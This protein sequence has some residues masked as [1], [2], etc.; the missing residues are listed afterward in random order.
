MAAR[1]L[2][3]EACMKLARQTAMVLV[4]ALSA[5]AADDGELPSEEGIAGEENGDSKGDRDDAA[6]TTFD[7]WASP[8]WSEIRKVFTSAAAYEEYF[9]V[10]APPEVD[11]SRD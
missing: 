10:P 8:P 2:L 1:L 7:A 4:L 5:C 3:R 11:W 9:V 6:F